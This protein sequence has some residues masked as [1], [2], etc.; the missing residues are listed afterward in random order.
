MEPKHREEIQPLLEASMGTMQLVPWDA[1]A[2]FHA[3]SATDFTNFMKNV[4]TS[5]NLVGE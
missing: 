2:E 4:Y 3:K 5:D 1:C